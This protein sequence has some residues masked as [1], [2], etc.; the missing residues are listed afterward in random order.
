MPDDLTAFKL[1]DFNLGTDQ[2]QIGRLISLYFETPRRY[3]DRDANDQ[4]KLKEEH[5]LDYEP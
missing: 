3:V 1:E 2:D 4:K 5:L